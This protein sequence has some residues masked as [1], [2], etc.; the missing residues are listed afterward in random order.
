MN[1]SGDLKTVVPATNPGLAINTLGQ[2][3][4]LYQKLVSGKWET[5]FEYLS[6]AFTT[7]TNVLLANVPDSAGPGYSGVNPIG[8]Y[9]NVIAVG[10][11]RP[12]TTGSQ[13]LLFRF[14]RTTVPVVATSGVGAK[15]PVAA[16][17]A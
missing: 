7:S 10:K 5:H 17:R 2:V 13:V 4:F 1:W 3:G 9:A 8:D 6:D 16:S 14:R 15:K 12:V 11:L